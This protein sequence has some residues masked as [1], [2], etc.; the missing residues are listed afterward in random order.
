MRGLVE[1][2]AKGTCH[3]PCK[4]IKVRNPQ[5]RCVMPSS[6][7][8]MTDTELN[9]DIVNNLNFINDY[10]SEGK[11]YKDV[12]VEY[13]ASPIFFYLMAIYLIHL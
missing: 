9:K 3:K 2:V 12:G 8:A 6:S 10:I 11:E 7:S 5:F 1:N 4:T 13:G